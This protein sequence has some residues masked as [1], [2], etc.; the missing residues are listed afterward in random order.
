[1]LFRYDGFRVYDIAGEVIKDVK[2]P[3]AEQVYDQQFVREDQESCLQV[4]YNDGTVRTYSAKDGELTGEEQGEKKD[5]NLSEV[6]FT[7]LYRIESPLH[8]TP[9]VFDRES[10]KQVCQLEEDA[11]LTYV[12]QA[13]EYLV[14]QYI[15]AEGEFYGQLLNRKCEILADLPNLCDVIGDRLIFDYPTGNL[16]E[17]R[18][19]NINELI[20]LAQK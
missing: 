6:F 7:D 14:T 12:T 5:E 13:G 10:G 9:A 19:Y 17:T 1:M 11:Y 4:I 15:T 18:I 3:N 20:E 8:G 16:R 2:I